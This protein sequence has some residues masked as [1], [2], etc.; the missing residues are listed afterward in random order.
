MTRSKF[1]N[2]ENVLSVSIKS[3]LHLKENYLNFD[4]LIFFLQ[5][6]YS[7]YY[8]IFEHPWK[9]DRNHIRAKH[10]EEFEYPPIVCSLCEFIA[11]FETTMQQHITRCHVNDDDEENNQ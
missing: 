3:Q 11:L 7:F 10:Y 5:T 6:G 4:C 2:E 9:S 1:L 8:I